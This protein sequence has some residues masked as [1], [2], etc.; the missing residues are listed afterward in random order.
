MINEK[1]FII[2]GSYRNYKIFS[3]VLSE[4]KYSNV[5]FH[6]VG[7][8][9]NLKK[10]IEVKESQVSSKTIQEAE[11]KIPK[12]E[13]AILKNPPLGVS[14][15]MFVPPRQSKREFPIPCNPVIGSILE[16]S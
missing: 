5:V 8:F 15:T 1:I 7:F 10:K 14:G 9:N 4:L 6:A 11:E 3:K 13:K 16:A 12:L 2:S